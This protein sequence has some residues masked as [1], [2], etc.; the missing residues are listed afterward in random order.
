[1]KK[2]KGKSKSKKP[3]QTEPKFN[4]VYCIINLIAPRVGQYIEEEE[5]S[6]D[7]EH[8]HD[9]KHTHMEDSNEEDLQ[10]ELLD[11][12]DLKKLYDSISK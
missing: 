1:V 9:E 11:E 7:E 8:E 12:K 5:E 6:E 10:P 3:K 2:P 4:E